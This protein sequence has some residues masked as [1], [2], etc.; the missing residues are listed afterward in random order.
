[1][2]RQIKSYYILS[3]W[4]GLILL[5]VMVLFPVVALADDPPAPT[6]LQ[7]ES[8]KVCRHVVEPDDFVLVFHY[9]IHYD[10]DQ[11]DTPA[12]KLFTFRL[13]DTDGIDQLGAIVP[14]A[15][16]NSGYDKGCA[17]F[18]FPAD[19][20]P[21]WEQSYIVR[22]SGNPE[23]FSSPP[24]VNRTLVTSDY[25][26][27]ETTEENQIV[28]GNYIIGVAT[29]IQTNWSITLIYSSDLGTILNSTG[30]SYFR[31]AIPSLQVMAPQIFGVQVGTPQ[32]TPTE[33][34]QAQGSAYET[35]FEDTWVGKNLS[36]FGDQ[37]HV[38]WTVITGILIF[39]IIV[40]LAIVCQMRYGTVKPVMIGGILVMLGGTVMG[41]ISA[42]IMAIVTIFFA[43]F[44]AYVWFF[45]TG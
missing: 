18:Y 37:F 43:L 2:G 5:L 4:L 32:Y 28:L 26:Q 39:A 31:G 21:D 24:L 15:Y 12:N 6:N 30:E 36:Y 45:R 20:A 27:M 9:N 38:R 23:Y 11:P 16:Y 25:S 3:L 19:D 14:Y 10:T 13:M 22:I 33:W 41:W 29:Y 34:T 42:A 17:A 8:V 40:A 44:L 35:R 1:M 7:I